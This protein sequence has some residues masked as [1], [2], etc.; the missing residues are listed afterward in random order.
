MSDSFAIFPDVQDHCRLAP[1]SSSRWKYCPGSARTDLP[2]E[3]GPEA[4]L[5]T[6]AH[7]YAASILSDKPLSFEDLAKIDLLDDDVYR[8]MVLN[9][10][11]YIDFVNSL[12]G[13]LRVETKVMHPT[14]AEFGGTVDAI[15]VTADEIHIVDLKYGKMFVPS[16]LN[17]Q[18]LCYL[19]LVSKLYPHI[20]KF[21]YTI[22]QPRVQDGRIAT[23]VATMDEINAQELS[24]IEASV[25][26]SII[27]GGHCQWCPL[28]DTCKVAWEHGLAIAQ[29]DFDDDRVSNDRCTQ[30]IKFE[31]TFNKLVAKAK[32]Q[33]LGLIYKGEKVEGW[34]AG[35]SYGH[36][37]FKDP[38][39]VSALL[40]VNDIDPELL[41]DRKLK[42]PA[43]LEKVIPKS[44]LAAETYKPF[45]GVSLVPR[46]S[47]LK[48]A[49]LSAFDQIA[50]QFPIES[51]DSGDDSV[52]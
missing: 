7:A 24:V 39:R 37:K 17:D 47:R 21:K 35:M 52:F 45:L 4:E 10:Q 18:L 15:K 38:E 8:E 44:M 13:V 36:R 2:D 16:Y 20:K 12:P 28:L 34:K 3:S 14:L 40:E 42:S 22:V 5:G 11:L 29:T 1:S 31:A 6:L 27:P 49:D 50:E 46:T 32:A 19:V 43:Q 25:D 33:L 41:Y 48:E 9:V 26:D 51:S 23:E 30:I